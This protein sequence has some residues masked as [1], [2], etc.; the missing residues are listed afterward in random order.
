MFGVGCILTSYRNSYRKFSNAYL[1]SLANSEVKNLALK[2]KRFCVS[3]SSIL[4]ARDCSCC[5]LIKQ[6]NNDPDTLWI[7]F[8]RICRIFQVHLIDI[9][10]APYNCFRK[11]L[12]YLLTYWY[13]LI[14]AKSFI[15]FI[16]A[17]A[18]LSFRAYYP[19]WIVNCGEAAWLITK[20]DPREQRH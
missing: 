18:I 16:L 14:K 1:I 10:G 4:Q 11:L 13:L 7:H 5:S 12:T 6:L 9:G 20:P 8:T 3:G 17:E 15:Y 2:F 19:R